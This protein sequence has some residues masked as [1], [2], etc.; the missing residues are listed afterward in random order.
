MIIKKT[1]AQNKKFKE[2][3]P[4]NQALKLYDQLI[5]SENTVVVARLMIFGA[6]TRFIAPLLFFTGLVTLFLSIK[7]RTRVQTDPATIIVQ[8][9]PF[10]YIRDKDIKFQTAIAGLGL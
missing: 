8:A 9:N 7:L 10:L 6:E 1:K 3:Y 2:L 4:S 5:G